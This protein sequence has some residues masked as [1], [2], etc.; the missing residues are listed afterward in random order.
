MKLPLAIILA[1]FALTVAPAAR[2]GQPS[3]S[4][5][6]SLAPAPGTGENGHPMQSVGKVGEKTYSWA[7]GRAWMSLGDDAKVSM[8]V[9]IEQ[10]VILSVRENWDA[11]PKGD[12][13]VLVKTAERL[14]VNG[15]PFNQ[16]VLEMDKLYIDSD[17]DLIPVVD[18]YLYVVL[19]LKKTPP[20]QLKKFLNRLRKTYAPPP[21]VMQPMKKP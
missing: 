10:G 3:Q 2:A 12:Q 1:V 21:I 14:T 15:V 16:V 19:E 9:G 8:V 11:V 5:P 6:S 18:A 17:N 7:N 13:P 20:N 4:A